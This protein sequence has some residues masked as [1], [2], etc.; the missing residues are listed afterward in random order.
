MRFA[1]R[2]AMFHLV[3]RT[4]PDQGRVFPLAPGSSVQVGRSQS[5][6]VQ[7]TDPAV[8]RVHFKLEVGPD[9]AVLVNLSTQG[10]LVNGQPA[11]DRPLRP[12]DM[13]RLGN[14]E[15]HYL[16]ADE[17]VATLLPQPAPAPAA[18]VV[19]PLDTLVG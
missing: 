4:G 2:P 15:L 13:I 12:G 10:T 19:R 18:P 11:T 16:I 17:S 9:Q 3:A 8:S 5:A 14:T 7:L 1:R 6:A